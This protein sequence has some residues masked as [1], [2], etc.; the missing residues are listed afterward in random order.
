[1]SLQRPEQPASP[2]APHGAVAVPGLAEKLS[3]ASTNVRVGC[4][5][6]L[7]MIGEGAKG[8]LPALL[9]ALDDREAGVR[10]GAA[11]ALGKLGPAAAKAAPALVRRLETDSRDVQWAAAS[12]LGSL[13]PVA[14]G[15]SLPW[16]APSAV[17]TRRCASTPR[18]RWGVSARTPPR[19]SP[20]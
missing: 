19:P 10:Q 13:G 4:T 1:M 5:V 8:A 14:K 18:W 12:A 11:L 6:A 9:E 15:P 2:A 7:R 20:P 17:P 16:S 3:S